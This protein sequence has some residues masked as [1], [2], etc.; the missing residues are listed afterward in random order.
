VIDATDLFTLGSFNDFIIMRGFHF[1]LGSFAYLNDK[2]YELTLRNILIERISP[3][4][5][6]SP[7]KKSYKVMKRINL[8][9]NKD[10]YD[11]KINKISKNYSRCYICSILLT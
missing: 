6:D 4:E 7:V 1:N 10:Y 9:S 11:S 2:K 3:S 5:N 8:V